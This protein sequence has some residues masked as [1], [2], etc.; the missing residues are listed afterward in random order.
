MRQVV[1]QTDLN[2]YSANQHNIRNYLLSQCII[3]AHQ[4]DLA[5]RQPYQ[6]E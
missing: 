4:D 6:S 5:I 2:E 1:I 3:V